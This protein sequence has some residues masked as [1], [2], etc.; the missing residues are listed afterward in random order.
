MRLLAWESWNGSRTCLL[1]PMGCRMIGKMIEHLT[2]F[3]FFNC[4]EHLTCMLDK[5]KLG[6]VLA[7]LGPVWG[8][9]LAY[10]DRILAPS[11]PNLGSSRPPS[12]ARIASISRCPNK[13]S[14]HFAMLLRMDPILA[15]PI[16][17][18]LGL[19]WAHLGSILPPPIWAWSWLGLALSRRLYTNM[20][21][22]NLALYT[23]YPGTS[24]PHVGSILA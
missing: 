23:R 21:S 24:W 17:A 8:L 7:H 15:G 5:I 6:L 19:T 9:I 16:S 20:V 14:G 18:Y 13:P 11:G 1:W 12:K 10:L 3:A 22:G 4:A 2:C